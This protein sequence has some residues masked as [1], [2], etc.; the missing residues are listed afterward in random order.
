MDNTDFGPTSSLPRKCWYDLYLL[1]SLIA[2][3]SVEWSRNRVVSAIFYLWTS[4]NCGPQ[5][6]II[7]RGGWR[8]RETGFRLCGPSILL[9]FHSS[10]LISSPLLFTVCFILTWSVNFLFHSPWD[11]FPGGILGSYH[12]MKIISHMIKLILNWL[13]TLLEKR[14]LFT[15]FLCLSIHQQRDDKVW[16]IPIIGFMQLLKW[17]KCINM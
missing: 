13:N 6:H 8:S 3:G 4:L 14:M 9:A 1:I 12:C 17:L 5:N 10:S 2:P 15:K 7:S 16:F 11:C